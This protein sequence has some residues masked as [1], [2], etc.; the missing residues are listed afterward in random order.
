MLAAKSIGPHGVKKRYFREGG[1]GSLM[2]MPRPLSRFQ[3]KADIKSYPLRYC[4]FQY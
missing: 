1:R 2:I 3:I 4:L